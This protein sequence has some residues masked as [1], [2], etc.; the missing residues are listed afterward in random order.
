MNWYLPTD[1]LLLLTLGGKHLDI[2]EA[3]QTLSLQSSQISLFLGAVL[4]SRWHHVFLFSTHCL[5]WVWEA[6]F[7][8]DLLAAA[9]K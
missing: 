9:Q 6:S 3:N 1:M 7:D 2:T 8:F 4:P 5:I